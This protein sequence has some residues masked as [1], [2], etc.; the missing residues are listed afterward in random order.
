MK[1][2]SEESIA[3]LLVDQPSTTMSLRHWNTDEC[4]FFD[5][6]DSQ[7]NSSLI[8]VIFHAE[9]NPAGG[10]AAQMI[11]SSF[12]YMASTLLDL[13]RLILVS[14]L[15]ASSYYGFHYPTLFMATT[16]IRDYNMLPHGMLRSTSPSIYS[17]ETSSLARLN[18]RQ[19][20]DQV[21]NSLTQCEGCSNPPVVR[22]SQ[23]TE[24]GVEE[25]SFE[26]IAL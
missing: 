20:E 25:M 7:L 21:N 3:V 26:N 22:I 9:I 10:I 4:A 23:T 16:L 11:I 17:P 8:Q 18:R 14:G 2:D 6:G 19:Q 12:L 24:N 5:V 13:M 15:A 1:L